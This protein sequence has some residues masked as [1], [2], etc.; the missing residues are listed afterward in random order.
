MKTHNTIA[1]AQTFIFAIF[2]VSFSLTLDNKLG[3]F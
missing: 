1:I 2:S 3:E